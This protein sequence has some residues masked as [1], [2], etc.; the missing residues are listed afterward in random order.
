MTKTAAVLLVLGAATLVAGVS[1]WT[2]PGATVLAG[3]LLLAVGVLM[4]DVD[5]LRGRRADR[6]AA[7]SS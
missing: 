7:G 2:I 1:M 4:L 6:K 5:V 3:A